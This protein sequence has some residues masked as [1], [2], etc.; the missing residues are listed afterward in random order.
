M[1]PTHLASARCRSH[2][3]G[4]SPLEMC[5]KCILRSLVSLCRTAV[6]AILLFSK[7]SG[8][9]KNRGERWWRLGTADAVNK[10]FQ[11][12]GGSSQVVA[13][14]RGTVSFFWTG[15]GL[16]Q[17][18]APVAVVNNPASRK[19]RYIP[20]ENDLRGRMALLWDF[21]SLRSFTGD[22]QMVCLPP[23]K[24]PSLQL[25]TEVNWN[26]NL[27]VAAVG[28]ELK[29]KLNSKRSEPPPVGISFVKDLKKG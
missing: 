13:S 28:E 19:K 5:Y 9:S 26:G 25:S 20:Y 8:K 10:M 2:A 1:K 24:P 4:Q 7:L 6:D 15:D 14:L 3:I 12:G 21:E 23:G 29:G 11:Q 17:C 18:N 27:P 16:W 22:R